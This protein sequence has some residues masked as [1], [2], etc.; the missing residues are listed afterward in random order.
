V[1]DKIS[2]IV[3]THRTPLGWFLGFAVGFF[4]L[5]VLNI[6]IVKLLFTGIGIWGNNIPVG[7]AFDIINFVWWIGIGHAGTLISAILLLFRQQ[8]RTFDQPV[9]GS[10]DAVR[11][12]RARRCSRCST[13]GVP[14]LAAYWLFPYPNTMGLWPQFRSPADLGRVRRLDLLHRVA[15]VLVHRTDPRPCDAARLGG[16]EAR[17]PDLRRARARVAA[18]RRGTGSGTRRFY[19]LLAGLSTPLVLSVHTVVSFD[20][21]VSQL[22]GWHATIFPPYF[23]AGAIYSG[24]ADG[25]D[26][27]DPDAQGLRASRLHHHAPHPQHD[28]DHAGHRDDRGVWLHE[29]GVLR[30]VQRQP[31]RGL[32]D[33]EPHDRALRAVLLDADRDQRLHDPVVLVQE[34]AGQHRAAVHPVAAGER[35]HVARA[36]HHHRHRACTATSCPSSWDM[37]APTRW[38]FGMFTGTIGLFLS[39]FFLFVRLLPA[40]SI[41]EVRTL[42]PEAK[43]KTAEHHG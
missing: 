6:T 38:D 17:P 42:V 9:R 35:R 30:L 11:G 15:A 27:G 4:F 40:I 25:D 32:H 34:G 19:L 24:F 37:Y 22:P 29:R 16:I 8:W 3:L 7:W 33:A 21:A 10:D 41:F 18:A 13:P 39:L 28:E 23:V 43:L 36:L 5:M 14:W 12:R 31:L 2:S 20:F 26:A 1:T